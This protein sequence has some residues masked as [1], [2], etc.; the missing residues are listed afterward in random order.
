MVA[1]LFGSE[2][3]EWLVNFGDRETSHIDAEFVRRN[4]FLQFEREEFLIPSGVKGKLVVRQDVGA[5]LSD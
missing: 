2:T 3:I 1:W 5:F 4:Q